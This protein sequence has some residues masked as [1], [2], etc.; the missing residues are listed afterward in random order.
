V[1][2]A[3]HQD[4]RRQQQDFGPRRRIV[5]RGDDLLESSPENFVSSQPRSDQDE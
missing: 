4:R 3:R 5:G 2:Q 1:P